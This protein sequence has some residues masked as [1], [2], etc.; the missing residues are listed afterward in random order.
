MKTRNEVKISEDKT[1][2]DWKALR[3][4]LEPG[5]NREA[6]V[7][8]CTEFFRARLETRY[9]GPIKLLQQCSNKKGEGFSIVV[10][11]CSL[12]EFF[13]SIL[14]GSSYRTPS[15]D[16]VSK[17]G[18]HEYTSSKRLFVKFL[19]STVPFKN[20]FSNDEEAEDFY[21]NVRCALFHEARTK[22]GWKI[23]L[24]YKNA[25]PIDTKHKIVYRDNL[26]LAFHEFADWYC[27]HLLDCCELQKAFIRKFDSLCEE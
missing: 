6:W 7:G 9:Y 5:K 13:A 21:K 16:R 14:E 1:V 3:S 8:A 2:S 22:G 24:G 17:L 12:I 26:Q 18:N 23:L 10:L 19:C 11:Q 20:Y 4:T 25:P 15:S 27:E